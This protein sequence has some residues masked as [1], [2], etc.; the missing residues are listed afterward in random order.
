M[1]IFLENKLKSE[2]EKKGFSGRRLARYVFGALNDMNAMHGNQETR[3][4]KQMQAKHD[5]KVSK[6]AAERIRKKAQ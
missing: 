6:E 4:G 1:P 3:R 2:A 5:A